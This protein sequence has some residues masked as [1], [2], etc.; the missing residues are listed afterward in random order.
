MIVREAELEDA[1]AVAQL[2]KE[3]GFEVAA[4][5][6]A[7]RLAM[8]H[9]VGL[10]S[11]IAES[12]QVAGC[13]TWHVMD[14]LHR[15]RP[16]GRISMLIVSSAQRNCGIGGALVREAEARMAARGCGLAE[17]TSNLNLGLAHS[18]YE[19]LGYARTSYRFAKT[20]T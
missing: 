4:A 1:P 7:E 14:V 6:V 15:P 16:V 17:V 19:H 13:L 11:L 3:L 18:F 5:E 20:L 12:D 9:T 2:I 8:L 10:P